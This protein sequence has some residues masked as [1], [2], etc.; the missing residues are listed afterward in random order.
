MQISEK[1]VDV[2]FFSLAI[3]AMLASVVANFLALRNNFTFSDEGLY[4]CLMR[5]LPPGRDSRFHLLF[6]NLLGDDVFANRFTCWLAQILGSLVLAF[7]LYSWVDVPLSFSKKKTFSFMFLWGVLYLGQMSIVPC[8][9]F[10][11]ITI[12]KIVVE[13]ALG[14]VFVGL[15]RQKQICIVLSGFA[16]AFLFPVMITN[17]VLIPLLYILILMLSNRK[18]KDIIGFTIGIVLF[19]VYY[20]VFVESPNKVVASFLEQTSETMQKGNGEYGLKWLIMTEIVS[21]LY[22]TKCFFIAV[23][24]YGSYFLVVR[25]NCFSCK[26][27]WQLIILSMLSISVLLYA[28]T[29]VSPVFVFPYKEVYTHYWQNDL[30]WIFLFLLLLANLVDGNMYKKE[31]VIVCLLS[32]CPICLTFG[33]NVQFYY[34]GGAYLVFVAPAIVYLAY[35]RSFVWKATLILALGLCFCVFLLQI[36]GGRNWEGQKYFGNNHIPVNSIGVNQNLKIEQRW[37]DELKSCQK[38]IPQG[39]VLCSCRHWGMVYLLDY[40][41]VCYDYAVEKND[42]VRFK[43]IIDEELDING[44]VW[45]IYYYNNEELDFVE[46]MEVLGQS[47]DYNI[48][49]DTVEITE[50]LLTIYSLITREQ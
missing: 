47:G 22:L 6:G 34:R 17:I 20:F 49:A 43:T 27:R 31:I 24:L 14:L 32:L 26:K 7:G 38:H 18:W 8:P 37:I 35:K 42:D 13:V 28:W 16:I 25:R 40:D 3:V 15:F 48:K 36:I 33:S 46:K 4:M 44:L 45:A 12:N 1:R 41:P 5:D 10:N 2:C 23:A 11:Y 19:F 9:S 21:I 50:G 39:R 30:Y 29:Y